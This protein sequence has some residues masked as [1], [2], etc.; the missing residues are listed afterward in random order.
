MNRYPLWKYAILAVAL[1]VGLLYTAPNFFGEAPAV[2]VSSGKVTVKLDA[3]F[4]TRVQQV[5]EQAGLKPDFVQF[6]GNSVKARLAN[7][8]TQIK[9]K[10]ALSRALNP[11]PAN[12][13]YIVALNLLSRSPAWLTALHA[14]PMYLGLDLRGGVHFLM[15][16]DMKAAL[17]K[18]AEALTGDVRTLLRD[19]N[20]RHAGITRDGDSLKC[21][22]ATRATLARRRRCWPTSCPTCNG[23]SRRRGGDFK[24]RGTLK[25]G[26]AAVQEQ[27]LKQNITTLH[28][29]VNELGVAEPVIQQQ[30]A[31][32]RGGATARRAGHGQGQGHHRPHRHAGSAHGQRKRR[33]ARG[34]AR[35]RPGAL[36]QRALPRAQRRSRS[37]SCAR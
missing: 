17:T 14:L 18:R 36:R 8:D 15:Q 20:I 30:G 9:A 32:P 12:P 33:G 25:P 29:R 19:K 6:D 31:G 22:S 16:V 34:R 10:D 24:L 21:A 23:R 26:R 4:A 13:S 11:D 5:L 27:A 3:G 28:N 37:S 35:R 2:Q 1:L 7:T